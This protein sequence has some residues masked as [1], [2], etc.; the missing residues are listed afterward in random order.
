M[1][2]KSTPEASENI[3][4]PRK[5]I[6]VNG[7]DVT[8]L[9]TRELY[10]NKDGK[11]VTVSL[12]DYS[13]QLI[14]EE[15]KSL[16]DFLNTWKEADKKEAIVKELEE[17]GV[18]VADLLEAVDKNLDL[19][20]IICHVAFDQKPL[21]RKERANQVKKRNYFTKYGE[22]ARKV[23]D[24]LID[25]YADEGIQNMESMDV[26]RVNPF[27]QFGTPFEIVKYFGGKEQY[28]AAIKELEQAIY[29]IA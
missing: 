2:K 10:F 12:K 5:K 4:E 28:L 8:L 6:Y 25:K 17:Q 27:S 16:N 22:Q 7:V 19:F 1:K 18:P 3:Q 29:G 9:N 20:D 26:L 15:F 14:Q 24:A 13:K 11:L 21:T 23:I